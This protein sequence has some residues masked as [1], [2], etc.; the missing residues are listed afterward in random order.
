MQ[1]DERERVQ[2]Q[3]ITD[4]TVSIRATLD[5]KEAPRSTATA[6]PA[7]DSEINKQLIRIRKKTEAIEEGL[8]S[9][10]STIANEV[11]CPIKQ[12]RLPIDF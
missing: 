4:N 11:K 8:Q 6:T 2:L 12:N 1:R 3:K 5:S 7:Q 9:R 10:L